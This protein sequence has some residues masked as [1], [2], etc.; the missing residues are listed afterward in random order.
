MLHIG[1]IG[2]G[3]M[4]T[5]HAKV[6]SEMHDLALVGVADSIKEKADQVAGELFTTAF[7]DYRDLISYVDAVMI[8]TPPFE[9]T[10][11]VIDCAEA[12]VHIFVEKPIALDLE[13]ADR[14]LEAAEITDVILMIGYVLRFTHPFQILHETFAKGKLGRL[15][16]CWTRRYMPYD[17]SGRWY[18]DQSKS[19][20][21]ELDFAS[22]DIDW[23]RWVGGEVRQVCGRVERVRPGIQADEHVHAVMLFDKGMG[24]VDASWAPG[25]S[26]SSIGILG[27]KGSMIVDRDGTIRQKIGEEEE[28]VI[29]PR[30]GETIQK[31]FVRCATQKRT[32]KVTGYDGR[33][34]L[35]IVLAIQESSM[36]GH[37]VEVEHKS[38]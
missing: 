8:C 34:A 27:T 4:G 14:M 2:C 33:A 36:A 16:N 30:K 23:L 17:T 31:H 13:S 20:G 12:G 19:G 26:D 21:V 18:G 29:R 6:I 5:H 25:L 9:R 22:H 11:I 15:V 38:K 3:G 10:E 37:S 28:T 32:P 1:I 24:S 7:E 35:E